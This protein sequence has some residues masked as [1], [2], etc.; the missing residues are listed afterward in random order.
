MVAESSRRAVRTALQVLISLPTVVPV[1]YAALG[2]LAALV[3]ADAPVVRLGTS[4]L[5]GVTAVCRIMGWAE[6]QGW[7]PALLRSVEH[8]PG[9]HEAPSG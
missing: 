3:G 1:L 9:R 8:E 5:V 4:V 7:W 6:D 2:W